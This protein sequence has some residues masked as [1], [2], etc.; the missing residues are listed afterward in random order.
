M[1]S[2]YESKL[3]N[4]KLL[5]YKTSITLESLDTIGSNAPSLGR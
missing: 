2:A 1:P 3:F 4:F 5:N